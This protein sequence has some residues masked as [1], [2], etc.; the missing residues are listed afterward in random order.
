MLKKSK[1]A[2]QLVAKPSHEPVKRATYKDFLAESRTTLHFL[3]QRFAACNKLICCKTG[4]IRR[5]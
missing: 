5:W 1:V 4:L 2:Q 3:Q